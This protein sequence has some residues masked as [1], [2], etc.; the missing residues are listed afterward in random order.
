MNHIQVLEGN[1]AETAIRQ[2]KNVVALSSRQDGSPTV[3]LLKQTGYIVA[4]VI[5]KGTLTQDILKTIFEAAKTTGQPSMTAIGL[6]S[7]E[8]L[9]CYA[10][11]MTFEG[12]DELRSTSCSVVNFVLYA[13]APDWLVIF[14]D[15]LYVAYGPPAF[16][17]ALV[18]DVGQAYQDLES[19]INALAAEFQ[20]DIPSYVAQ[21]IERMGSYLD[22][23]L[24]KLGE[25]YPKAQAGELVSVL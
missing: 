3:S 7:A 20:G 11:P 19:K 6:Y 5:H 15:Q 17:N 9:H 13:G 18:G 2:L 10:I 8:E 21:E 24:I 4:P 14:D 23:A 25:D 1:D 12:L 16:V 22:S